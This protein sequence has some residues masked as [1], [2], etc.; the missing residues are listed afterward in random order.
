MSNAI[1]ARSPYFTASGIKGSYL[2]AGDSYNFKTNTVVS[3]KPK[4]TSP[5]FNESTDS[6]NILGPY[7]A[8]LLATR[9]V[10]QKAV[11]NSG[12][13]TTPADFPKNTPKF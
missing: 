8:S 1:V 12:S 4:I 2:T 13:T 11:Y 5:A 3:T 9:L 10:N 7:Q 6:K